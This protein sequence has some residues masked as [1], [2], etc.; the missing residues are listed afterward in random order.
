MLSETRIKKIDMKKIYF[1]VKISNLQ[2]NPD[3][4]GI[5]NMSGVYFIVLV[6]IK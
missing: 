5:Q 4:E 6:F 1:L 3:A 2:K